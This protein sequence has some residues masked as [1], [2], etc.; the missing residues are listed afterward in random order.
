MLHTTTPTLASAHP[1][2]AVKNYRWI[3]DGSLLDY[4]FNNNFHC[5]DRKCT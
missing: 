1:D 4:E 2:V 5:R 3:L